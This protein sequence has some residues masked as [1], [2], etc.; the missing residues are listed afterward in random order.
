M[1]LVHGMESNVNVFAVLSF[2]AFGNE[3]HTAVNV[4]T[5]LYH[6]QG[7]SANISCKYYPSNDTDIITVK[8]T[9]N[10]NS[11]CS[12]MSMKS[13]I[14]QS[15]YD[16]IRFIWIQETYE[17][18]IEL[19]NLQINDSGTYSCIVTHLTPP[20]QKTMAV[21]ISIVTVFGE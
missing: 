13:W 16:H 20:P 18:F 15:C 19:L 14:N 2:A 21:I 11:L 17:I 8:L 10:N 7:D 1:Q 3:M 9:K 6:H 12:Y 5:T 4:T